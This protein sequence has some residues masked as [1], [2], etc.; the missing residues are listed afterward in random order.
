MLSRASEALLHVPLD[1]F[2]FISFKLPM[3][4]HFLFLSLLGVRKKGQQLH[5]YDQWQKPEVRSNLGENLSLND[6]IKSSREM[7]TE[8][9]LRTELWQKAHSK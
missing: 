3:C 5:Q 6:P 9:Q 2:S 8:R 7:D 4:V 1:M